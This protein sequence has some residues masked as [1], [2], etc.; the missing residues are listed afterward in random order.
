MKWLFLGLWC[1][2]QLLPET[3]AHAQLPQLTTLRAESVGQN[4]VLTW[5][6]AREPMQGAYIVER[7]TDGTQWKAIANVPAFFENRAETYQMV[8]RITSAYRYFRLRWQ[9]AGTAPETAPVL[10]TCY[11]ELNAANL[12]VRAVPN[13]AAQ[14]LS[15]HYTLDADKPILLRVFDQIGQEVWT[16]QLPSGEAGVYDVDVEFNAFQRG[17][18]LLVFTQVDQNLNLTETRVEY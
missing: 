18:Y 10:R 16:Q 6:V 8:H 5:E 3:V 2:G 15:L 12:F 13:P 7:S 17:I 4:I 9:Q 1:I 11:A 14:Q